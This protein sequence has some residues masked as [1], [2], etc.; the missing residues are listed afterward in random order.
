VFD[1][2]DDVK[3]AWTLR[4]DSVSD[5][6][7]IFRTETRVATTDADARAKFRRYWAFASPGITLIP[8]CRSVRFRSPHSERRSCGAGS[9]ALRARA[10]V[11]R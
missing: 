6:E 3:I 11:P 5:R 7:S 2:P 1:E 8:G 9:P 10:P 4:A